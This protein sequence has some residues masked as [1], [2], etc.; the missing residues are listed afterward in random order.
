MKIIVCGNS[1]T[2]KSDLT[3]AEIEKAATYRPES[4]LL[5]SEDGEVDFYLTTSERGSVSRNGILFEGESCD[6]TGCAVV[7]VPL[8]K[9]DGQTIQEAMAENYATIIE[10]AEQ[11]ETQVRDALVGIATL[12]TRM[13][14][15]ISV[16]G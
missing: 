9:K 2:F 10:K 3:I 12:L 6:G 14:N 16:V 4:V 11:V 1:V 15:K 5:K 13:S 7:T 8:Q